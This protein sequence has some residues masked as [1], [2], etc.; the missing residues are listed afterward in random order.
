[1]RKFRVKELEWKRE[2]TNKK[3]RRKV[4]RHTQKQIRRAVKQEIREVK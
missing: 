3:S 4:K 2:T 1:M